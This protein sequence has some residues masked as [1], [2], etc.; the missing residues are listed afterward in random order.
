MRPQTRPQPP[1][2]RIHLDRDRPCLTGAC[3]G[4]RGSA[5][6]RA[7]KKEGRKQSGRAGGHP[8]RRWAGHSCLPPFLRSSAGPDRTRPRKGVGRQGRSRTAHLTPVRRAPA[9]VGVGTVGKRESGRSSG[10]DIQFANNGRHTFDARP[11]AG[12]FEPRDR[13]LVAKNARRR[14]YLSPRRRYIAS[15][16]SAYLRPRVT[17]RP[18]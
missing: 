8:R 13:A 6:R 5:I 17:V 7:G 4:Q 16:R 12:P 10:I 11:V 2:S 3:A 9:N 14:F 1:V 15:V 18:S